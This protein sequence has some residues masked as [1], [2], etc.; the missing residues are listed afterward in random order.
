MCSQAT[1]FIIVIHLFLFLLLQPTPS[2]LAVMQKARAAAD[3]AEGVYLFD[4]AKRLSFWHDL[5]YKP[6]GQDSFTCVVEIP[7]NTTAKME[8]NKARPDNPI[9]QDRKNDR[10]RFFFFWGGGDGWYFSLFVCLVVS[11]AR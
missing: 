7:K 1:G 11:P 8:I 5:Q 3:G 10:P 4:G 6:A 2:V 9:V